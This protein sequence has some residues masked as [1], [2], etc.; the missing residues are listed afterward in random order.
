M[1][2]FVTMTSDLG[3]MVPTARPNLPPTEDINN[4]IFLGRSQFHNFPVCLAFD[5]LLGA[6][7]IIIGKIRTGKSTTAQA[8]LIRLH[9]LYET[10]ILI[11]DPHGEY[12]ELV[13]RNGGTV[14]DMKSEKINPCRLGKGL[15]ITEKAQQ[16]VDMLETVFNL[17][18]PQSYHLTEYAKLGYKEFGDNLTFDYIIGKLQQESKRNTT[19]AVTFRAILTRI[20]L[21]SESIFGDTSSLPISELTKGLV[22]VDLSKLN[23]D[24]YRTMAML[25]ILQFIYNDMLSNQ[26]RETPVNEDEPLRLEIMIDE[27]GRVASHEKSVATKLVKESGKFKIGLMFGFQDLSDLDT[28]ILSNYGFMIVHKLDNSDYISR[29][30]KDGNFTKGQ[31]SR[32]Q[33]LPVGTAYV[34]LNFKDASVSRPFLVKIEREELPPHSPIYD[35]PR[36]RN[37]RASRPKTSQISEIRTEETKISKVRN[38][39]KLNNLQHK[40]ETK[41]SYAI[42]EL[43]LKLAKSIQENPSFNVTQ[44]YSDIETDP[45]SGNET[46]KSLLSKGYIKEEYLKNK[47][48]ILSLTKTATEELGIQ[49]TTD[50]FGGGLHINLINNIASLLKELGHHCEIEKLV[51]DCKKTDIVVDSKYAVEVEMREFK[52]TN[53]HKN[54]GLDFDKVIIVCY[55]KEQLDNFKTKLENME[56][57]ED[58]RK[59]VTVI[60]YTSLCKKEKLTE[61]FGDATNAK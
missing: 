14:I 60:D 37:F 15:S 54:L 50:R 4:G 29:I 30:Q 28:K 35:M 42:S 43:E 12:A 48:K 26:G 10:N 45:Y 2:G 34:K 32:I 23:N 41:D 53:V 3:Y 6:T 13:R 39:P 58:R 46:K 11:F 17:T 5:K 22:C 52:H 19:L 55:R 36:K 20:G 24:T 38:S 61:I 18:P 1:K 44:H 27:A 40:E 47:G 21:L 57:R 51:G 7:G 16:L 25:S 8:I 49:Q 56:L 31:A 59:N 33:S 9:Q